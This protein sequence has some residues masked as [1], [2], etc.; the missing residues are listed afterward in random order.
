MLE[1]MGLKLTYIITLAAMQDKCS[2]AVNMRDLKF[3]NEKKGNFALFFQVSDISI[4]M[5]I[6]TSYTMK[7]YVKWTYSI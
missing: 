7:H 6:S 4:A 3:S 5:V 2:S 1:K